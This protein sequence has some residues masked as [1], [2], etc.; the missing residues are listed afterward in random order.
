MLDSRSKTNS[1]R[2]SPPKRFLVV[3]FTVNRRQHQQQT[4]SPTK[5]TRFGRIF[6]NANV[7]IEGKG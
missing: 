5:I 4:Q 7:D 1:R 3:R 6:D 2:Q